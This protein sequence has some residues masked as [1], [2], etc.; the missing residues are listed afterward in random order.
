MHPNLDHHYDGWAFERDD[1][2]IV[3]RKH[4]P[5]GVLAAVCVWVDGT[6]YAVAAPRIIV[7]EVTEMAEALDIEQQCTKIRAAVKKRQSEL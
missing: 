3:A 2:G 7:E 6:T 4:T 5:D 1:M